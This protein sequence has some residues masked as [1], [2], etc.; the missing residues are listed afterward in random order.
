MPTID[1]CSDALVIRELP[2]GDHDKLLTLLTADRGRISVIAKGARSLKSSYHAAS[3]AFVW[4]N[5]ELHQKG[6]LVWL[7][8]ASVIEPFTKMQG[9]IEQLYLAQY[10]ADAAYELSGEAEPAPDLLRLTLNTYHALCSEKFPEE[11]VKAVFELRA[12][13]MSG[14][15]PDLTACGRCGTRSADGWYLD[16][17]N[18]CLVCAKC[19]ANAPAP[20]AVRESGDGIDADLASADAYGTRSILIHVGDSV[21]A[22]MRYAITAPPAKMLSFE[23]R[24]PADGANLA[25]AAEKYLLNH[26]ERG[27]ASL[28]LYHSIRIM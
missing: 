25:S 16:V 28:R 14:Y 2:Q 18:G 12:A 13:A 27:F 24:D 6:E 4:G 9:D 22:A 11:K 23:L 17:M 8:D 26:L 7:R 19:A 15:E 3:R 10:V 1:F 5:F 21:I 20:G